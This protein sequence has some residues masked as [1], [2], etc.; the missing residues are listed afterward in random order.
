MFS[1]HHEAVRPA[2]IVSTMRPDDARADVAALVV[3]ALQRDGT[4]AGRSP[5]TIISQA[6]GQRRIRGVTGSNH[7]RQPIRA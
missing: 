2:S 6:I 5:M 3:R 4:A 1:V 7:E